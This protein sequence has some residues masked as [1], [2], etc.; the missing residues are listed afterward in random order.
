M[1]IV[2]GM[3]MIWTV[4]HIPACGRQRGLGG[5]TRTA[6]WRNDRAGYICN[7]CNCKGTPTG[8]KAAP[9]PK[10]PPH[11]NPSYSELILCTEGCHLV[12]RADTLS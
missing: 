10:R 4:V 11:R 8:R 9:P 1:Y 2:H 5:G 12:L 6:I 3:Y 7:A